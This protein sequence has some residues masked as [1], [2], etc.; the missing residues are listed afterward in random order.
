[1]IVR[2][3]FWP[4]TPAARASVHLIQQRQFRRSHPDVHYA[5][6]VFRYMR[7]YA[8]LFSEHCLFLSIDD[9]HPV[10]VGEPAF[11]VAAAERGRRVLVGVQEEFQVGD[12]DFTKFS[13]V[14]S[15]TLLCDLPSEICGSWYEGQVFVLLKDVIFQP[16]SP[17]RMHVSFIK[18]S[19]LLPVTI[20]LSSFCTLM[21]VQ[22]IA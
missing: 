5:A 11:P 13:L 6:A 7:E 1:M 9:K 8:L 3:Q 4:K 16:S 17:I 2:L 18:S 15:V 20:F 12:H 10:K 21:E 14:P 19:I 22:T